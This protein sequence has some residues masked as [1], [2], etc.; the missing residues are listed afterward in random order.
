MPLSCVQAFLPPLLKFA[1]SFALGVAIVPR[2]SAFL[3][4]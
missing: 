2:A 1:G 3:L 4:H